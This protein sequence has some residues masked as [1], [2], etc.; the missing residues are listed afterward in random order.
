MPK[1]TAQKV[2]PKSTNY[3]SMS[4]IPKEIENV[5]SPT[6]VGKQKKTIWPFETVAKPPSAFFEPIV[7]KTLSIIHVI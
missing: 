3:K 2:T 6:S 4:A 1:K 7:E 5:C